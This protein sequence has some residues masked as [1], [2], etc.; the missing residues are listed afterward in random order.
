MPIDF[1][2]P[3]YSQQYE[4]LTCKDKVAAFIGGIG[5]GKTHSLK[6][7]ILKNAVLYPNINGLIAA[8]TY[9]QLTTATLKNVTDT[10]DE[11]EIPYNL[12]RK[13][14]SLILNIN[15]GA[16]IYCR[17]L[18]KYQNIRGIEVG[19][20]ALDELAYAKDLA[21]KVVLGRLRLKNSPLEVRIA[22]TPNGFNWL[23]ETLNQPGVRSIRASSHD[24]PFLPEE[25]LKDLESTYDEKFYKQEVLGDY[26]DTTSGSVYYN[27]S[28]KKHIKTINIKN[29]VSNTLYFGVDFNVDPITA[30]IGV[31][32]N[33]IL[34]ILD[35]V[36]LRDSNTFKL[37]ESVKEKHKKWQTVYGFNNRIPICY[38]DATGAARKTSSTTTD[39]K[40]LKQFNF[41]VKNNRS[42]PAIKDRYNSVNFALDKNRIVISEKCKWLKKDLERM[43]WENKDRL[44]S[45]ISDALGYLVWGLMPIKNP[46]RNFNTHV[47]NNLF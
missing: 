43:C 16:D 17:S 15:N 30:V 20:L 18:E 1:N 38:P 24:N 23:Y 41:Y 25:Y 11:F 8:N 28:V 10:L 27:F 32:E 45:H 7:Y 9:E 21:Y 2:I 46:K 29:F 44:I 22:S 19:W 33:G 13:K 36:Y 37:S 6:A 40:I 5:S 35:E 12:A 39:H 42:N 3:L 26:T 34:Y 14:G 31:F 47:T 4:F